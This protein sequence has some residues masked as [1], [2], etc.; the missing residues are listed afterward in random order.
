MPRSPKQ[1][2]ASPL[3]LRRRWS[4]EDARQVLEQ[5][6]AS[7]LSVREFAA[8]TSVDAQR[9]YRWRT[10]LGPGRAA[11]SAFIEVRPAAAATIEVVLRSG[12]VLR[13]PEGFGDE[14]LRR[15]VAVLEDSERRC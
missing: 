4:A 12:H 7:G 10:Q 5:L 2:A 11:P 6:A 9:L 1:L 14:A 3:L 8:Q 15:L 13:V